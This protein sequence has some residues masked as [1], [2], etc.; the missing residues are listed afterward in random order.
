[1][2]I[3]HGPSASAD[4][5]APLISVAPC[6]PFGDRRWP[7]HLLLPRVDRPSISVIRWVSPRSS[8]KACRAPDRRG[9]RDHGSPRCRQ[10]LPLTTTSNN[11]WRDEWG[12]RTELAQYPLPLRWL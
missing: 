2:P 6:L 1:M 4:L 8:D 10:R 9:P 5:S 12:L 7:L 11:C 3:V